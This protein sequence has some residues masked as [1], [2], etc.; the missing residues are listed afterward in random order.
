MLDTFQVIA[1]SDPKFPYAIQD[2]NGEIM[3]LFHYES[4]AELVADF[5]TKHNKGQ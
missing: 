2:S 5:L 3:A 1:C 4:E